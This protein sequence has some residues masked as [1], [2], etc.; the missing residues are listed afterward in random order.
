[1]RRVTRR[2][3]ASE[4]RFEAGP[5]PETLPPRR[6]TISSSPRAHGRQD[7]VA[8]SDLAS[9]TLELGGKSRRRRRQ[10]TSAGAETP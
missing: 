1:M 5:P 6:S 7:D 2:F 8:R 9:I 3:P 10:P 4:S